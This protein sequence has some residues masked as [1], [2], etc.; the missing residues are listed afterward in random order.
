MN[1]HRH[2]AESALRA[3]EAMPAPADDYAE[4]SD[5]VGVAQAHAHLALVHEIA[6]LRERLFPEPESVTEEAPPVALE[7]PE[8]KHLASDAIVGQDG[9]PRLP[10]AVKR[11]CSECNASPGYPCASPS[12]FTVPGGYHRARFD[13]IPF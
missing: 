5:L 7:R 8:W 9:Y 11:H 3:I 1:Q 13:G 10:D 2:D 6:T 12:G 4:R